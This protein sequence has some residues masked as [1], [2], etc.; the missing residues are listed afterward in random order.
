MKVY[1][2]NSV[3]SAIAR[4]DIPQEFEAI[5][6]IHKAYDAGILDLWTSKFTS[7]EIENAPA[8]KRRP[9]LQSGATSGESP[10]WGEGCVKITFA[11][12]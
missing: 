6:K 8:D 10:L 2:D 7:E 1:L 4:D 12:T 5:G 3:V 11:Q 9:M